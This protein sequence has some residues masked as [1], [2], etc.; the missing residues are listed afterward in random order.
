MYQTTHR[1]STDPSGLWAPLRPSLQA[2]DVEALSATALGLL[3]GVVKDK[4]QQKGF[5]S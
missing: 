5:R 4:P 2:L 3:V 1:K